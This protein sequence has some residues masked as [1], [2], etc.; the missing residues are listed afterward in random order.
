MAI[1]PLLLSPPLEP[2]PLVSM[3]EPGVD[4]EDAVDDESGEF[5]RV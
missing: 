1:L 5:V 2:F 3:L 4:V